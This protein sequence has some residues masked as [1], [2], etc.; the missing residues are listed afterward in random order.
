M[1]YVSALQAQEDVKLTKNIY[2]AI[3]SDLKA[4]LPVLFD[5]SNIVKY[6]Y[7]TTWF[8]QIYSVKIKRNPIV[9]LP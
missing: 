5:R 4:E 1:N 3:N 6:A 9:F 8:V 2:E 7:M